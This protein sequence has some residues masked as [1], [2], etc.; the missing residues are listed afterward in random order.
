L[1]LIAVGAIVY[2]GSI[3]LLFGAGWLRSLVRG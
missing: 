1:L 2:A 3:L